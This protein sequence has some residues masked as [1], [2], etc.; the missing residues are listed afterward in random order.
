MHINDIYTD[1]VG[2]SFDTLKFDAIAGSPTLSDATGLSIPTSTTITEVGTDQDTYTYPVNMLNRS[3]FIYVTATATDATAES[4]FRIQNTAA[5]GVNSVVEIGVIGPNLRMRWTTAAGTPSD[6]TVTYNATSMAYWRIRHS[7]TTGYVYWET[8]PDG[9]AW[10]IRRSAS[11]ASLT[12][13]DFTQVKVILSA[14]RP[15]TV[16]NSPFVIRY[17]NTTTAV[18][19]GTKWINEDWRVFD[20]TSYTTG[21]AIRIGNWMVNAGTPQF[22]AVSGGTGWAGYFSNALKITTGL[23]MTAITPNRSGLSDVDISFRMKFAA[24]DIVQI[25]WRYTAT[26]YMFLKMDFVNQRLQIWKVVASVSSLIYTYPFTIDAN[27]HQ[28]RIINVVDLAIVSQDGVELFAVSTPVPPLNSGVFQIY[29]ESATNTQIA[30]LKMNRSTQPITLNTFTMERPQNPPSGYATS[31]VAT[32]HQFEYLRLEDDNGNTFVIMPSYRSVWLRDLDMGAA[33]SRAVINDRPLSDGSRDYTRYH[34]PKSVSM[35]LYV[36]KDSYGTVMNYTDALSS[37][38]LPGRKIR[39]I[40]KPQGSVERYINLTGSQFQAPITSINHEYT[41]MTLQ[42]TAPDGG[43]YTTAIN[44]LAIAGINVP[45]VFRNGG[46]DRAE[47]VIRFDVSNGA[48]TG[49]HAITLVNETYESLHSGEYARLSVNNVPMSAPQGGSAT[50]NNYVQVNYKERSV[51]FLGVGDQA[52]SRQ[53]LLSQSFW[54]PLEPGNSIL[55]SPTADFV[56]ISWKDK[57]LV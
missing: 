1:W 13:I 22:V 46:S 14:Y 52:A 35:S 54:F 26:D 40:F 23:N 39:M 53:T 36:L 11:Y 33:A 17:F 3:S 28:Y 7:S 38:A 6:T 12:G 29:G 57:F 15:T 37:W 27:W 19:Y 5:T 47:P 21:S 20:A 8:S 18:N 31:V 45:G 56:E 48:S 10:S 42:W 41:E 44:Y 51:S 16:G 49:A 30:D 34:G 43:S 50:R 25:R 4:R 32:K 9:F 55:T 2:G 24:S